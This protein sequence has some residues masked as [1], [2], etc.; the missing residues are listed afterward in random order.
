MKWW[1]SAEVQAEFGQ[2]LQII[3]G[4]EYYWNTANG[5]AFAQLPWDSDDKEVILEQLEWTLEAPRA[6]ASYM[7]E[8][9]L[10]DA[11]N[12]VVLGAKS[13]SVRE[14]LDDAQKNIKRET[15]RKLEEFGYV[16]NGVT[17]QEYEV[18]TVEK[19][20]EIIKRCKEGK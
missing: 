17:I 18:P 4:D 16:E 2:R 15:Q 13:S 11:Y 1:S 5:E 7:V 14:A 6:L 8:R 20:R 3:Y 12:L 19:V 9:E 10:S